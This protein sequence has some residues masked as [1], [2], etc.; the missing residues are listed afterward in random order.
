MSV[1]LD[2]LHEVTLRLE[3]SQDW[4]TEYLETFAD[5]DIVDTWVEPETPEYEFYLLVRREEAFDEAS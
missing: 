1:N 4:P 3:A 5:W 2:L